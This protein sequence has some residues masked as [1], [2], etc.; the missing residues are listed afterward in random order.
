VLSCGIVQRFH[1]RA[2]DPF[3]IGQHLVIPESEHA[4]PA[5]LQILCSLHVTFHTIGF[6]MLAAIELDDNA[7]MMTGEVREV[8]ADRSLAAKMRAVG[9]QGSQVL[10]Q[11]AL[12]VGDFS[13][14]LAGARNARIKLSRLIVCGHAAPPTPDPSPPRFAR[15]GGELNRRAS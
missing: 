8:G 4:I 13:P 9:L 2:H 14:Q 12:G 5:V 15:G 6:T 7:C 3:D 10:P 11:L 1:N